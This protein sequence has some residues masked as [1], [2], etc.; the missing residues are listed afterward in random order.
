MRPEGYTSGQ[1]DVREGGAVGIERDM[2]EFSRRIEEQAARGEAPSRAD[3]VEGAA[4][5]LG[6]VGKLIMLLL[7]LGVIIFMVYACASA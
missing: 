2:D 7:V 1:T 5:M 4:L 3:K 6:M